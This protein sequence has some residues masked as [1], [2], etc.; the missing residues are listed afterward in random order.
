[1]TKWRFDII[2]WTMTNEAIQN[3]E[4]I[5]AIK[6]QLSCG[7]IAYDEARTQAEP[8]IAKINAKAREIAKKYNQRP[9][10]V[11]FNEIFR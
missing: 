9:R 3:R 2:I 5:E 7:Q 4:K 1:M 11:S 8:I 6:A 10:L